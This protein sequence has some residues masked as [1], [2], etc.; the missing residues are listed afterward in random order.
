MEGA[1]IHSGRCPYFV[2]TLLVPRLVDN[3]ARG[4]E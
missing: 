3:S 4:A 2:A 1:K